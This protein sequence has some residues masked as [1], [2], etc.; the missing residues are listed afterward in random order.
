MLK[1]VLLLDGTSFY[2]QGGSAQE[3]L[4]EIALAKKLIGTAQ[5]DS[6]KKET[7]NDY[8][9]I[10]KA[11][12]NGQV[13][14]PAELQDL[15]TSQVTIK[16][17]TLFSLIRGFYEFEPQDPNQLTAKHVLIPISPEK[18]LNDCVKATYPAG[19]I[20]KEFEGLDKKTFFFGPRL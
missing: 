14:P 20:K 16:L 9:K 12:M 15:V 8:N 17:K 11:I 18:L 2:V 6:L 7:G 4:G 13:V 19:R 3:T 1:R 10:E 5:Y